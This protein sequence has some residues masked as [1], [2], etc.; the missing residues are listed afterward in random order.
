[1]QKETDEEGRR[2]EKEKTDEDKAKKE[3]ADYCAT[4]QRFF[5]QA[6]QNSR[7]PDGERKR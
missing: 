1:M 5:V 7:T 4:M 2:R 3:R 6:V